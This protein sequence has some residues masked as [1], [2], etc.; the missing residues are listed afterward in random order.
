M[1]LHLELASAAQCV[2]AEGKACGG[3]RRGARASRASAE[4]AAKRRRLVGGLLKT[5]GSAAPGQQCTQC[6]TQVRSRPPAAGLPQLLLQLLK[7]P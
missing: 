6:G 7:K 3:K 4:K 1:T 2:R 5:V